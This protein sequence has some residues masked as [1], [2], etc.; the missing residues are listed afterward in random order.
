VYPAKFVVNYK[1]NG[2]PSETSYSIRDV[3]GNLIF[4]RNSHTANT[5]YKDT[6]EFADGCYRFEFLDAGKNGLSFYSF[7]NDGAGFVRFRRAESIS[8][9]RTFNA[10]F[11]TSILHFFT[12]GGTLST[13]EPSPESFDFEL[14]PNPADTY[15]DIRLGYQPDNVRM[16]LSDA[17]GKQILS[18]E[19]DGSGNMTRID[20]SALSPGIY[21]IQATGSRGTAIKKFII[22]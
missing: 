7:N 11:G 9:L 1:T 6:L 17:S 16:V 18:K 20:V 14:F 3:Q 15:L 21:F 2:A 5:E 10:N 12:V 13:E 8:N 4:S 22:K 19:N